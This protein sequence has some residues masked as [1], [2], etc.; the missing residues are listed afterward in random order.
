MIFTFWYI[1]S[2]IFIPLAKVK[3]IYSILYKNQETH[4]GLISPQFNPVAQSCLTL[5][6]PHELQHARPPCPSPTPGVHSDSRPSSQWCHPAIS[7]SVVPFSSCPQCLPASESFSIGPNI[8]QWPQRIPW[9]KHGR[10]ACLPLMVL[11]WLCTI[12]FAP[13]PPE[14]L[15]STS[16]VLLHPL[17]SH[18]VYTQLVYTPCHP[19]FLPS[20]WVHP[21]GRQVAPHFHIAK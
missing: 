17:R 20:A 1:L 7:S 4:V 10:L 11:G 19:G 6:D 8:I 5:C 12:C 13:F 9:K 15:P 18:S 16:S 3:S 14:A 2:L 21:M